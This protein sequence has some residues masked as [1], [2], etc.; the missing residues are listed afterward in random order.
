MNPVTENAIKHYELWE[1][2]AGKIVV[3]DQIECRLVVRLNHATYPYKHSYLTVRAVPT[4]KGKTCEAYQSERRKLGDD[5]SFD[6]LADDQLA[7]AVLRF[8][9]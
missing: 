5:W 4:A 8:V 6:V 3:I 2:Y 1:P 9:S 7:G